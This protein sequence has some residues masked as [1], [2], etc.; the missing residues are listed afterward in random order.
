MIAEIAS[1]IAPLFI[2][3]GI[4]Y[5]WERLGPPFDAKSVT[6]LALVIGMPCLV[7]STLTKLDVSQQ[8]FLDISAAFGV[9]ILGFLVTGVVVL[10]VA[11][12]PLT[13]F[14]PT[15]T[16]SNTGNMGL[17][18]SLFAFGETGLAL[19]ICIYVISSVFSFVVGWSIY[20]GRL[21]I[22]VLYNNPLLY[23]VA[24]ALVCLIWDISPP[25]WLANTTELLGALTIPLTVIAL[26]VS[27][28]KLKVSGF[29]RT[30]TLSVVKL[31]SGFAVGV[32]VA[33]LF[34]LTGVAKGVLIIGC[35]M[36]VAVHNYVFAL[37]FQRGPEE[38]ASMIILSTLISMATLP[39]LL[40][41]VL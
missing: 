8:A 18:L 37:R 11:R 32:V 6:S 40:W 12:L 13:T 26:G 30:L 2:C 14:L 24:A 22:D 39:L 19:A 31:A 17:P 16:A 25:R 29:W 20:A 15:F 33:D 9:A 5:F 34:G 27:I 7:F 36:P 38:N 4:G 35:S 1:I 23:A 10:K 41:Y 28:A 3:A 21:G